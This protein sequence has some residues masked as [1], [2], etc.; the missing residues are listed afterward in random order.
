MCSKVLS[1]ALS[2]GTHRLRYVAGKNIEPVVG[3]GVTPCVRHITV[4]DE[5]HVAAGADQTEEEFVSYWQEHYG[6]DLSGTS[7]GG[8]TKIVGGL[9]MSKQGMDGPRSSL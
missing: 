6:L 4:T 2:D 7:E 9:L 8:L 5:Q 1:E 3:D